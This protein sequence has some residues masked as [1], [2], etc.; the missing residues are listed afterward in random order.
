MKPGR[1]GALA[2]CALGVLSLGCKRGTSALGSDA[3]GSSTNAALPL[4]QLSPD[5]L[6]AVRYPASFTLKSDK[7]AEGSTMVL[8]GTGDAHGV[9]TFVSKGD[10]SLSSEALA[11]QFYKPEDLETIIRKGPGSCAGR[12]GV[13]ILTTKIVQTFPFVGRRCYAVVG[14]TGF[15]SAYVVMKKYQDTN[16]PTLRAMADSAEFLK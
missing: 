4:R 2:L 14:T 11:E 8:S 16:E 6:I 15:I 7:Y 10:I 3:G 5:G 1:L 12:P 13:E 9:V